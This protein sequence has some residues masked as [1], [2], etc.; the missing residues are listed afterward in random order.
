MCVRADTR[1]RRRCVYCAPPPPPPFSLFLLHTWEQ[2]SEETTLKQQTHSHSV[3]LFHCFCFQPHPWIITTSCCCGPAAS[4]Q[5]SASNKH[6]THTHT[7]VKRDVR[8][9]RQVLMMDCL[10]FLITVYNWRAPVAMET[11]GSQ[12]R[13]QFRVAL[14]MHRGSQLYLK[15]CI[16]GYYLTLNSTWSFVT[17]TLSLFLFLKFSV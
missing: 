8:Q 9:V 3:C 1:G 2:Q 12:Y 4:C 11:D 5:V 6:H 13:L 15:R 17:L 7:D 14:Q 16:H 10:G